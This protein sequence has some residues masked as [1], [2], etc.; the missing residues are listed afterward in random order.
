MNNTFSLEQIAKSGDLNAGLITK[1]YKLDKKTKFKKIQSVNP[2]SK[3]SEKAKELQISSST[4]Q[5]YR[6]EINLLS[7]YKIPPSS[8]TLTKK[9]KSSNPSE[10][11]TKMSSNDL[12]LTSK[13]VN[14]NE[15]LVSEK[16]KS[17][18]LRGGDANDDSAKNEQILLNNF[19]LPKNRLS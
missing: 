18:I 9:Q 19:F 13:D 4:L 7:P 10:H 17:K 8:N 16:V 11:D 1:Q 5:C 14:E 15:K 3:Q 6:R 2:K 12:K